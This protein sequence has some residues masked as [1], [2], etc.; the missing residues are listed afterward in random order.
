MYLSQQCMCH[1]IYI[2]YIVSSQVLVFAKTN[3]VLVI[4]IAL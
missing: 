3:L 4:S 1:I 2:N